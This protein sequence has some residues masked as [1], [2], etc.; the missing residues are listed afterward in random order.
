MK[1]ACQAMLLSAAL[2][3]ACQVDSEVGSNALKLVDATPAV[4]AF[5]PFA[6]SDGI[7]N[8]GN[9][10]IDYPFDPG[11]DSPDD[12]E[13]APP[14]QLPACWNLIDD[15]GDGIIDFPHDPVC[16]SAS[17][18]DETDPVIPPECAD[19][20]DNDG[21]GE[22]DYPEDIGCYAAGDPDESSVTS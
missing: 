14:A 10:L 4:D 7:D 1:A 17:D 22:I 15:D 5:R 2:L 8:D 12:D 11:C 6:C 16:V 13:E 21:N 20:L 19:G 9:G 18:L 3:T